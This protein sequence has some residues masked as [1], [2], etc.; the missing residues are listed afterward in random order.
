MSVALVSSPATWGGE[1]RLMTHH[2]CEL[3]DE[4]VCAHPKGS[5]FHSRAM[6]EVYTRT[7]RHRPIALA[8]QNRSGK[9]VAL[10]VS[11][12]IETLPGL[13]SRFASRDVMFAEP[14]CNDDEEG[15]AGLRLLL[16][17]HDALVKK[18]AMFTEV[19]PL[20]AGEAEQR[21]LQNSGYEFLDYLNYLV[22]LDRSEQ[23]LWSATSKNQR[24]A[25]RKAERQGVTVFEDSS[26]NAVS[27]LYG[28]LEDTY[29]HA[30]VPLPDLSL[31]EQ[32]ISGLPRE[33]F[34]L[35]FASYRGSTVAVSL[36]LIHKDLVYG[37][38]GG[39][40]RIPGVSAYA[41]LQWEVIL[42]AKRMGYRLYDM[43]GAGWPDEAYGPREHKAKYG[44]ELVRFGRYRKVHAPW[45]LW[46]AELAFETAR[47]LISPKPRNSSIQLQV[48]ND[49]EE[50]QATT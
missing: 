2:E 35:T 3:W 23:E 28:L 33:Q 44:G 12:V 45:R 10:L 14:I 29:G 6:I 9:V 1:L 4:F 49:G 27:V 36:E 46:M 38:Y 42:W 31:F 13:A 25:I 22:H 41:L 34:R 11:V 37:W 47:G 43:G 7:K 26:P 39:T 16:E 24:R 18:S 17:R 40:E 50:F 8:A 5:I 30:R 48:E 19:R 21:V 20:Y 32:V 15:V